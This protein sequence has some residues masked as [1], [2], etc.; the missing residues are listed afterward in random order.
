[1]MI[2]EPSEK[3]ESRKA[4]GFFVESES[5]IAAGPRAQGSDER[6]GK[7]ARSLSHRHHRSEYLLFVLDRQGIG[8][9]QALDGIGDSRPDSS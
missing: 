7:R 5:A 3:L 6:I 4:E 2:A 1:M 9:K 8:L